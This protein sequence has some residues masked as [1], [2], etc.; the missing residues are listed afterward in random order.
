MA[1]TP[2]TPRKKKRA[3]SGNAEEPGAIALDDIL[4][5]LQ[6]TFSRISARS[7][8]VPGDQA[9]AIIAGEVEFDMSVKLEPTEDRLIHAA[10]G[11]ILLNVKGTLQ[12]DVR[13]VEEKAEPSA[14][15]KG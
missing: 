5:A 3:A 13:V 4:I 8:H 2:R 12:T 7:A 11:S 10:T 15:E 6:K 1:K 14:R 9:R